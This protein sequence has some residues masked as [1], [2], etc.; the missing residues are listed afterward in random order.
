MVRVATLNLADKIKSQLPAE[1]VN[2]M[3]VTGGIAQR[4]SQ[5]LYLVGGVVRD[6]MLGRPNLDL[7]LVIEG[8]ALSLAKELAAVFPGKM[9][10]HPRFGTA[11]LQGVKWSVD[12]ATARSETYAR[13][14]ALPTVRPGTIKDDLFR[15]DFTI[16]AIAIELNPGRYGQLLDLYGG[17]D[18]IE[19]KLVRILHEKSFID[20]AT[21]IWRAL[22]YEQRLGF[23]LEPLT[24]K[25]LKRHINYLDMISGDRIRHELELALKE[26]C[27]EKV[28]RRADELG[29]LVKLHPALRGDDWLAEKL[30]QARQVATEVPSVGLY[31]ALLAYRL[32]G[33]EVEQLISY[34]KLPR[35]TARNLRDTVNLRDKLGLLRKPGMARS[36]IYFRLNGY[37]PPAI[38]AN[39]IA[40]DSAVVRERLNLFLAKLRYVRPTLTGADLKA[41]GVMPGPR[42]KE[43]LNRLLEAR[44][45]GRVTSKR[46]E[47]EL[48]KTWLNKWGGAG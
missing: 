21:R 19:H 45:D 30:A 29:V 16:N 8:D 20:D 15:R 42:M 39:A 43:I 6:L 40:T 23:R 2:L 32:T 46:G 9:V 33:V 7:D 31:L 4:Q 38:T 24:L 11:K 13:P 18:D 34:L 12:M 37:F 48:V 44:L 36:K 28:L 41:M 17:N 1:L 14:G 3:R 5:N 10:T 27:P 26:E 35:T 22:R 25:L 47:A